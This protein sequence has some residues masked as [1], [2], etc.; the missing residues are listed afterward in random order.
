MENEIVRKI[1]WTRKRPIKNGWKK[2][3]KREKQNIVKNKN[4]LAVGELVL[5]LVPLEFVLRHFSSTSAIIRIR[6]SRG[7]LAC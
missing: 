7:G 2:Y 6:T 1:G 4:R 5:K 3:R